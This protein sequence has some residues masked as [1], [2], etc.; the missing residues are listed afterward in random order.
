[1]RWAGYVEG[2]GE[3]RYGYKI[4]VGKPDGKRSLQRPRSRWE[5]A[6][7]IYLNENG[8]EVVDWKHLVQVSGQ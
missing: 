4:L 2:L 8:W 5:D 7:I 6:T 3:M 1:M